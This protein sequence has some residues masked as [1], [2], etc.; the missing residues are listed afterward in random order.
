MPPDRRRIAGGKPMSEDVPEGA[1]ASRGARNPRHLAVAASLMIALALAVV[2]IEAGAWGRRVALGELRESAGV[3]LQIRSTALR[4]EFERRRAIPIVLAQDPDIARLLATPP[5]PAQID[6]VNRK[7]AVI[8]TA[9]S[10]SA[11]YVMDSSGM[12]LSAS[13]WQAD[14]SFVGHNFGFRSYF[15]SALERGEGEFFAL[16]SVSQKPGFYVGRAVY[17]KRSATPIGVVVLKI[18]FDDVEQQ[19]R[20]SPVHVLVTDPNGV[21]LLTDEPAWR[22][23]TIE[24]LTQGMLDDLRRSRQFGDTELTPLV[25]KPKPGADGAALID[26]GRGSRAGIAM[27]TY[28]SLSTPVA[29]TSLQL[30]TL[31]PVASQIHREEASAS[32]LAALLVLGVAA[33]AVCFWWRHIQVKLHAVRQRRLF[34]D[35]ERRVVLRTADLK[36]SYNRLRSEIAERERVESVLRQAQDNLVHAEKLAALGQMAAGLLHE[37]RQPLAA[38]RSYA[39]NALVLYDRGRTREVR[40]NLSS[41]AALTERIDQIMQHLRVFARKASGRF[42]PVSVRTAINGSTEL[43]AHRFR[44]ERITLLEEMPPG[45]LAVW[46]EQVRIEQVLVNLLQ[47]AADAVKGHP[48]PAITLSARRVGSQVILT[49]TDNGCGIAPD[50]VPRLFSAFFTTKEDGKGL[51]LGLYISKGIVDDLGGEVSIQAADAGGTTVCVALRAV[52][53]AGT[54]VA[55]ESGTALVAVEAVDTEDVS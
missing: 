40:E 45:D 24:P 3:E 27:T 32:L 20:A 8:A 49:V 1:H 55:S 50:H 30:H 12:T 41:I 35:L 10:A 14:D 4:G 36:A 23:R 29:S 11:I 47:N 18:Q 44:R 16:G 25:L 33:T 22:F 28:L 38:I 26:L 6:R 39:D 37:V 34:E 54:T 51:G 48:Q 7:L 5:D 13:N 15:Q 31:T 9:V 46:G 43:M 52:D 42:E 2:I 53:E 21:I 17:S 19:W